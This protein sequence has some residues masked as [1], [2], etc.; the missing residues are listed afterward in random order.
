M[1][2]LGQLPGSQIFETVAYFININIVCVY[3]GS[4]PGWVRATGTADGSGGVRDALLDEFDQRLG[5][6]AVAEVVGVVGA[7][8]VLRL[9]GEEL[10]EDGPEGVDVGTWVGRFPCRCCG[11]EYRGACDP[12]M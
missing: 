4:P 12:L 7:G 1:Y 9:A 3:L 11:P 6:A 10:E 5:R 2:P 8:A